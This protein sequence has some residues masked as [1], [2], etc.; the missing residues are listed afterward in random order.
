MSYEGNVGS[1]PW[2][3]ELGPLTP[4]GEDAKDE[5]A[6]GQVDHQHCARLKQGEATLVSLSQLWVNAHFRSETD[7]SC[8]DYHDKYSLETYT[9]QY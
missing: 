7:E 6:R 9:S 1:S 8:M 4:P 2:Q 3:A 5:E